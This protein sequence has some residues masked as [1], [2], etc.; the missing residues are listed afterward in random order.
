MLR[1]ERVFYTLHVPMPHDHVL[2]GEYETIGA[3]MYAAWRRMS[4]VGNMSGLTLFENVTFGSSYTSC[5]IIECV[6]D[7]QG[8]LVCDAHDMRKLKLF[9][10]NYPNKPQP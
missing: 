3:A 8:R 1:E 7:N 9:N 10:T 4:S 6:L 5:P 2:S